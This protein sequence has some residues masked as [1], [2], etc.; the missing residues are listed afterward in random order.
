MLSVDLLIKDKKTYRT[1]NI[2]GFVAYSAR[3][4]FVVK[5]MSDRD[6]WDSL[7]ARTAGWILYA[8]NPKSEYY[9]GGNAEYVNQC[10]GL[11]PEDYP[12]LIILGIGSD[13][14][15]QQRNYPISGDSVESVYNLIEK[16]V[17]II[18]ASVKRIHPKYKNSTNVFREVTASLDAELATAKWTHF[19][20]DFMKIVHTLLPFTKY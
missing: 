17:D 8:V 12:Q 5:V 9:A 3:N 14:I 1:A 15:M 20:S 18:S 6:F 19:S 16:I 7:N 2:F 11:K 13:R 10:L 4:P